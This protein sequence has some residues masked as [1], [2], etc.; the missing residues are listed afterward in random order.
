MPSAKRRFLL[1]NF[2]CS[3][4]F[5]VSVVDEKP[6]FGGFGEKECGSMGLQVKKCPD[7]YVAEE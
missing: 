3:T 1:S 4:R 5:H 2:C 7:L 6:W